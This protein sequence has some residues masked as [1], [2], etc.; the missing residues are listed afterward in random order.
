VIAA[1]AIALGL[2]SAAR[3]GGLYVEEYASNAMATAGAG[4]TASALDAGTVI[5]NPAGM[6]RLEGHQI[7]G[8]FTP[9]VGAVRFDKTENVGADGGNGGNGGEQGGKLIPILGSGYAHKLHDRVRLGVGL[10]ALSGASL[11]PSNNWTGQNELTEI[12]FQVLASNPGVAIKITDWLSIGGNALLTYGSLDWKFRGPASQQG[13]HIEDADDFQ[14]GG[15]ASI[16]LEPIEGLRFG[17]VYQSEI[18]LELSGKLNVPVGET[19]P[20]LDLDLPLPQAVRA[21]IY[22][23]A[24][25]KIALLAQFGWEEWSAA[26]NVSLG[27]GGTGTVVP[28]GFKNTWRMGFGVHYQLTPVWQLRTGYTYDSSALRNRDR[29]A[30]LPIDEQHRLGFGAIHRLSESTQVGLVFQWLHLGDGKLR[31][32]NVRGSYG[33]HEIFFFG[34][35]INWMTPS[36]RQ[37]F[38]MDDA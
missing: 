32:D 14:A 29:I 10:F 1:I 37:T 26:D 36:W 25:E 13:V 15:M 27:V 19:S 7:W 17:L 30:A 18:E 11:D 34:A 33:P 2:T 21:S 9:G 31:T 20:G 28:L 8:G 38:G 12:N 23:D 35:T 6:T 3:A 4:R 16:L 24:T 5:H 22:W